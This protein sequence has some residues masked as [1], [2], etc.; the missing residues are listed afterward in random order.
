MID[1][2]S[3]HSLVLRYPITCVGIHYTIIP[4]FFT[5]REIIA[6]SLMT[7]LHTFMI[8]V[9]PLC[10]YCS[11]AC[12]SLV[13][14]L[15]WNVFTTD[16]EIAPL[17]ITKAAPLYGNSFFSL[18]GQQLSRK[19]SRTQNNKNEHRKG[20]HISES[21]R[22]FYGWTFVRCRRGGT[23]TIASSYRI[24]CPY[25]S[26]NGSYRVLLPVACDVYTPIEIELK[27]NTPGVHYSLSE[28]RPTEC[29]P[30]TIMLPPVF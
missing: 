14:P 30:P 4:H 7:T 5:K 27:W 26:F 9:L 6:S 12:L 16:E 18:D 28:C 20:C 23:I 2:G 19:K 24:L 17:V 13:G 29:R 25:I 15:P 1:L 21:E 22:M 10:L 8:N 3:P 11:I